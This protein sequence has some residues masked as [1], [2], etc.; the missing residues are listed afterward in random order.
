MGMRIAFIGFGE[1][2]QAFQ[3]SLASHDPSLSFAGYDMLLDSADGDCR[4]AMQGA[5]VEVAST[6]EIAVRNADWIISSVTADQSRNAAL[7]VAPF[8]RAGQ[9]YF[10]INSVSPNTKR[11]NAALIT[12]GGAGYIDM[13]V[14]APVQ[15]REHR[16]PLLI[17][18]PLDV[19]TAER[20][21][22]LDFHY[23][24]AGDEVGS[25]AAIKMV[26]SLFVKGLEAITVEALLAAEASGCLPEIRDSLARSYAGLGWPDFAD[27]QFERVLKHGVRRAAEMRECAATLNELGLHGALATAIADVQA[28]TAE[29][30]R[31]DSPEGDPRPALADLVG[32]R[33][34]K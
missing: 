22:A 9:V 23:E 3:R 24:V 5:G 31:Q 32:R 17:A 8:A 12:A 28:M 25:A 26:R 29:A 2:G 7:S 33:T 34:R 27:Y 1:A 15:P 30:G 16:T 21:A 14:M 11:G 19:Q 18:G 4:A 13:A 20:L 10:D 6:P